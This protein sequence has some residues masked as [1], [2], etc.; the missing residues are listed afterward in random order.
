M[1]ESGRVRVN[2]T[3]V[4]ELGVRVVPGTD[5][6]EVDGQAVGVVEARW[7]LFHKPEGI[8]TTRS[9]PHGGRTVYDVLP[10]DAAGLRYVGRLD[11]D[12][13]GLLLMTNEGDVLHGLTHPSREVER[14]YRAT[15]EGVPTA[16]T[17]RILEGGVTLEDGPARA[18]RARIVSREGD[19]SVVGLVLIE[20]RNREVRRLLAR[21]GH[22]VI[23]LS[24]VRFGPIELGDLAPG[25]WRPLNEHERRRLRECAQAGE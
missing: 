11:R 7:L 6:V 21:V 23:R 13:E 18:V 15:V 10:A 19:R 17:L 25:A 3:V 20:G 12:T 1:M 2:G 24:R 8:L 9:D 22:E 5:V 4:R 16:D 14:E